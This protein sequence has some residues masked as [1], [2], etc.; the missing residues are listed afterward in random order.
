M[1]AT[2]RVL[3]FKVLQGGSGWKWEKK[4]WTRLKEASVF[5]WLALP[6]RVSLGRQRGTGWRV[7]GSWGSFW[8]VGEGCELRLLRERSLQRFAGVPHC[9]NA[10][11]LSLALLHSGYKEGISSFIYSISC[12]V[13]PKMAPF[14]LQNCPVPVCGWPPQSFPQKERPL[15]DTLFWACCCFLLDKEG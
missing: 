14:P 2:Q 11:G 6:E 4:N 10:T 5:W 8:R 1:W 15:M 3:K 9:G 7:M 12:H 13:D